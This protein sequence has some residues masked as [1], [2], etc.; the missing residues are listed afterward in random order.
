VIV[1][2]GDGV[3]CPEASSVFWTLG[4]RSL[5]SGIPGPAGIPVPV[6]SASSLRSLQRSWAQ[7]ARWENKALLTG[8]LPFQKHFSRV[9]GTGFEP[10]TSGL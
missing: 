3:N 6:G 10:V 8:V 9:A 1:L 5:A 4:F 7:P 2:S